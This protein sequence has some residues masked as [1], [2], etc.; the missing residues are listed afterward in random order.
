MPELQNPSKSSSF[1]NPRGRPTE[2]M[3]T[4]S[5]PK[6]DA[7]ASIVGPLTRNTWKGHAE[8]SDECGAPNSP[9]V[10]TPGTESGVIFFIPR[11]Q[12]VGWAVPGA[13][14][15]VCR[16]GRAAGGSVLSARRM[17][18][19]RWEG[20]GPWGQSRVPGGGEVDDYGW[21]HGLVVHGAHRGIHIGGRPI[22]H[23]SVP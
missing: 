6:Q 16:E 15:A 11:P 21:V 19:M 3:K 20:L 17:E 13:G 7:A 8:I 4:P 9:R 2:Q 14:Q 1:P 23:D 10:P 5:R 18:L 22:C 12:P